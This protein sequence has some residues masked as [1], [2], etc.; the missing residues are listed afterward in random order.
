MVLFAVYFY[1][2]CCSFFGRRVALC[3]LVLL[4]FNPTVLAQAGIVT[5]DLP[6]AVGA[7]VLVGE[8]A[9]YLRTPR[10]RQL[11]TFALAAGVAMMV[12]Y[13]VFGIMALTLP[14]WIG[15]TRSAKRARRQDRVAQMADSARAGGLRRLRRAPR[16]QPERHFDGTGMPV[17]GMLRSFDSRPGIGRHVPALPPPLY[18]SGRLAASA[19][20]RARPQHGLVARGARPR[21]ALWGEISQTGWPSYFPVMLLIKTPLPVLLLLVVALYFR[22]PLRDARA[23]RSRCSSSCRSDFS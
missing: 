5:T 7:F 8:F 18:P 2:F 15:W 1:A 19:N 6:A 12:K 11:S 9:R 14:F 23:S 22:S 16:L 10:R 17:G 3:G 4:A 13:T 21:L 20:G